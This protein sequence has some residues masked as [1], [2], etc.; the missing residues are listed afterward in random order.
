[1]FSIV[2]NT[3]TLCIDHHHVTDLQKEIFGISNL[4]FIVIFSF[5]MI[6]KITGYGFSYYWH[7]AWNKFDCIIVII[8]LIFINEDIISA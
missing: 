5:E 8:S 1:M 6:I 4:V 2:L 3:L 7:I